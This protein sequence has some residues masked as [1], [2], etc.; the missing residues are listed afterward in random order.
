MRCAARRWMRWA[1]WSGSRRPRTAR[2][3]TGWIS[4]RWAARPTTACC[5]RSGGGPSAPARS[6]WRVLAILLVF[7]GGFAGLLSLPLAFAPAAAAIAPA[8]VLAEPVGL[9]TLSFYAGALA[10]GALLA[11]AVTPPA[12]PP[13]GAGR[14]A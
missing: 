12:V 2:Q 11:L 4:C 3:P 1:R 9:P 5:L 13:G 8:A 14:A 7:A 10:A 6:R